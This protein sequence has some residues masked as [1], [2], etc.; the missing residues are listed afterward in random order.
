MSN[1]CLLTPAVEIRIL[2]TEFNVTDEAH[3]E[4][5]CDTGA[6]PPL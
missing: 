4:V 2:A 6:A 1:P 5:R 3:L